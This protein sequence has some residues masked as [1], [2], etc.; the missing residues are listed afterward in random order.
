MAETVICKKH[1]NM[2]T[3]QLYV[4][5]Y[6]HF[7]SSAQSNPVT[8]LELVREISSGSC[9]FKLLC[10]V[11]LMCRERWNHYKSFTHTFLWCNPWAQVKGWQHKDENQGRY[12]AGVASE[13]GRPSSNTCLD[14]GWCFEKNIDYVHISGR[15]QWFY[16]CWQNASKP[17]KTPRHTML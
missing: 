12:S 15:V 6:K 13:S 11:H 4:F 7:V 1:L 14:K 16:N 5:L 10:F 9:Q 3:S 17:W 2:E 8:R